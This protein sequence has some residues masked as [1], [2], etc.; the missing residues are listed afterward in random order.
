MVS[1]GPASPAIT[2]TEPRGTRHQGS[3]RRRRCRCSQA[4]VQGFPGTPNR[5]LCG[6]RYGGLAGV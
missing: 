1:P 2:E 4:R 3:D 6:R 5:R